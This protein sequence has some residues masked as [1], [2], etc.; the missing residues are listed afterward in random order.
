MTTAVG[1]CV[2]SADS[3]LAFR[4]D[5]TPSSSGKAKRNPMSKR[6]AVPTATAT[7]RKIETTSKTMRS[8]V[9]KNSSELE[10]DT[11]QRIKLEKYSSESEEQEGNSRKWLKDYFDEAKDMIKSDGG[12]PRWFSPLECGSHNRNSRSPLLLFLPG[13]DGVG[14]GLIRQHQRL[15][16]IFDVWCLHIPVTDRTSF[17]VS[18]LLK[19]IE[20]TIRSENCR[21]SNRPVYLVG[22]SLGACLALAVA[23]RN[24]DMD[25]VLILANP[26]TSFRKSLLQTI[27]PIPA[28]LMSGQMTLTL[29]YLLSLMTG[30]PL[31][32]AIDSIVK[33]LF[34]Q[35]TIQ[36]R[37][38]DFVAMSSYLPVLAN[39][40]PKE[41]LLW[42]LELLKSASAYANARL[43]AVKAQTLIL[44]S[45][46]DQLL[47][48][49][50]EGDRLCRALPNCQTRR[51]G[52]GGHFLFLED[53][54]D[55]VT[56]IKGA[57]YYRRGRI[58]DYVSDFIPPTTIEVNKV[59]EEYRW[60]V[61]LTSSVMLSTLP[62]GKIV[63]GLSGI[64]SEGPVLLVGNHMLLGLEALPM[65]PTFVIERNI[66]VRAI[67]HPM[68]FFNAKDGG[69]PDLV[70][71][72]TFRIM[73][74]VPVS[75]INFY[76]LV[77]SKAHV[78]LYPG[79]VR[80]AFH[81]KGEE[82]KLFWPESSEFVRVA[83]AFGAKIVPFGVVGEDDLAQ[84][85]LDYNDQMKI[86]YLR[87]RIE[88]QTEKVVSLS[89]VFVSFFPIQFFLL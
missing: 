3:S 75:A 37:S 67:A 65:V 79:G 41:T 13:I 64:P 68:V 1:A 16:E 17:T 35:S 58:V 12:P 25:L 70:T 34:L 11:K 60:M 84:I 33:G 9:E 87:S 66:L 29:S 47:P 85:V 21:S 50:E 76:K 54:V 18:G 46:R 71:Y 59:Y 73:G 44:C 62:D 78:L 5:M 6:L 63:R 51:F 19:L 83:A 32:M 38:Q 72:D 86:P 89:F 45:G 49:E 39:I 31:K 55:L 57:G 14:L 20:R 10:A 23:A 26:A 56:T 77:S 61:D 24:P 40:L 88:E 52:G 53:G 81:R 2:F 4:W 22:E 69:L 28:E 74:S 7:T 27:M 48:S 30:D 42:K 80:E 15:G 8:F 43:D 82:Y 36:E